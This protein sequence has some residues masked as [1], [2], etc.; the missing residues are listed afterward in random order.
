MARPPIDIDAKQVEKL[1]A[2][3]CSVQE[4]AG[5]F[6]CSR[7]T[8]ERR[9]AAELTKGRASG[10]M[11]LRDMQWKA[12]EKGNVAMLIWLG[13]QYL[14]QQDKLEQQHT[15]TP[16]DSKDKSIESAERIRQLAE[17]VLEGKK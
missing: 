13:K 10:K 12:A 14:D 6:E 9:F 1:A 2:L 4:I 17:K 15:L 3:H 5:F 11:K 8:I 16:D 7:D